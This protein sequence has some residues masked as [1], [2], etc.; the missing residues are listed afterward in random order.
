VVEDPVV[1]ARTSHTEAGE[2]DGEL[3]LLA[4]GD[5]LERELLVGMLVAHDLRPF[6][7][8]LLN[9]PIERAQRPHA[10]FMN[11]PR[12]LVNLGQLGHPSLSPR[13]V[14]LSSVLALSSSR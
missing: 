1:I 13:L 7:A 3:E 5:G 2:G 8:R 10:V 12:K 14:L 4:A 9:D 6:G 11:R